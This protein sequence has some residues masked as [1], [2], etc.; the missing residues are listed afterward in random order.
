MTGRARTNHNRSKA[1]TATSRRNGRNIGA[2]PPCLRTT[3]HHQT[4]DLELA[5]LKNDSQQPVLS[6]GSADG[7]AKLFDVRDGKGQHICVENSMYRSLVRANHLCYKTADTQQEKRKIASAIYDKIVALGGRFL[8]RNGDIKTEAESVDKIKKS[9]KDMKQKEN[10]L[11]TAEDSAE[12]KHMIAV[13]SGTKIA[14]KGRFV[15]VNDTLASETRS[16]KK[17]RKDMKPKPDEEIP[18]EH[19]TTT[20]QMLD[21]SSYSTIVYKGGRFLGVKDE[22]GTGSGSA[23][24]K[25]PLNDTKPKANEGITADGPMAA[26]LLSSPFPM[27]PS[28]T[29]WAVSEGADLLLGAQPSATMH[30]KLKLTVAAPNVFTTLTDHT[31]TDL[32]F[33]TC[34][35]HPSQLS[36]RCYF[37]SS[38]NN[39]GSLEWVL[40]TLNGLDDDSIL[41]SATIQRNEDR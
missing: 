41:C 39:N 10:E 36:E 16:S 23:G 9:L 31:V 13:A 2:G 24:I 29:D 4:G 6:D 1:K 21:S 26:T 3:T 5:C 12:A 30:Q 40:E 22:L 17:H 25:N 27:P 11:I 28:G 14:R 7:H 20:K 18:T 37:P 8:D 32:S 35:A 19:S 15:D 34:V 33:K 38:L